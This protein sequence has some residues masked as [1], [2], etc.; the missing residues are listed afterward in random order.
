MNHSTFKESLYEGLEFKKP[1]VK[2]MILKIVDLGF[3]YSIGK[4]DNYKKVKFEILEA[5]FQ[6]L[7]QNS[8][9]SK[10][11]FAENFPNIAKTAPC[12]YTT[13]G[14]LMQHFGLVKY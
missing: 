9:V 1:T 6:E 13:I 4:E 5:G 7:I 3:T 14:G 10:K 2:S 12:N 8:S 11:W